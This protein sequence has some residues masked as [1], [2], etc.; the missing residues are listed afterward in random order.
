V[1][2]P[3]ENEWLTCS[4]IP[5]SA[6]EDDGPTLV[7]EYKLVSVQMMQKKAVGKAAKNKL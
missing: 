2:E 4:L 1:A 6:I 5:D 7:G 3:G